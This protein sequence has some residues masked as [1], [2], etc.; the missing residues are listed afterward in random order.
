MKNTACICLASFVL[1]S[2]ATT[3][4]YGGKLADYGRQAGSWIG[5]KVESLFAK[6]G[7]PSSMQPQPDGG[8][9]IQYQRS[10]RVESAPTTAVPNP[11]AMPAPASPSMT[12][13]GTRTVGSGPQAAAPAAMDA[14]AANVRIVPCTTRYRTDSTGTIRSWTIDGEGCKAVEELPPQTQ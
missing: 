1:A 13:D 11:A 5:Q 12:D 6:E 9:I 2:C 14:K 4:E 10:Q 7:P 3:A 8:T